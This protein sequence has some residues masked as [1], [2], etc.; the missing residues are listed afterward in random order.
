MELKYTE[1][2]GL[3]EKQLAEH[4]TLYEG[5]VKKI[6]EIEEKLK[7]ADLA[8][9][10]ASYSEIRELKLEQGFVRNAIVL[11]ELYFENM[12]TKAL[13]AVGENKAK[14]SNNLAEK[15]NGVIVSNIEQ[16]FGS[17]AK[18]ESE[19]RALGIAARGWVVL[20]W[21][22]NL[23]KCVNYIADMHNQGGIWDTVPLLVMDV[24]EHAYF[25]DYGTKRVAYIEAFMGNI[26]WEV[27]NERF[28]A[29]KDK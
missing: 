21:D 16:S 13:D 20:A 29:I 27:V 8:S 5:Y 6:G 12:G 2:P 17:F 15:P 28:E 4:K 11:H 24:Y 18:W 9:A 1:L 19:F 25:M 26:D 10:N 7:T 23:N 14:I 3:S 22:N